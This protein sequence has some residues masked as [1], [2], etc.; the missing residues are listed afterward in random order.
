MPD[1]HQEK[2][3]RKVSR[4]I[5]ILS[6]ACYSLT[7]FGCTCEGNEIGNDYISRFSQGYSFFLSFNSFLFFPFLSFRILKPTRDNT[8]K[9]LM[10]T[11]PSLVERANTI[12]IV[13]GVADARVGHSEGFP[14]SHVLSTSRVI[15]SRKHPYFC[16]NFHVFYVFLFI[17]SIYL[18]IYF[19]VVYLKRK[20]KSITCKMKMISFI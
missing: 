20:K 5:F 8:Q 12:S 13:L 16:N 6:T 19:A 1:I 17:L 11:K 10:R 7:T 18:F 15:T 4:V 3:A 2:V 14:H 9:N